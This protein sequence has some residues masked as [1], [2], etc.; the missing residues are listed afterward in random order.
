[1][2]LYSDGISIAAKPHE[3]TLYTV[4]IS[5][6]NRSANE[7]AKHNRKHVFTTFRKSQMTD[8]TPNDIMDILLWELFAL[9]RGRIPKRGEDKKPTDQQEAGD[10]LNGAWGRCH[11]LK[12]GL[13]F[14][15]YIGAQHHINNK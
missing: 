14:W 6:L 7:N 8:D 12:H 10:Y 13:L 3:E 15:V 4:Y 1:M 11:Q 9:V 5:F 2:S